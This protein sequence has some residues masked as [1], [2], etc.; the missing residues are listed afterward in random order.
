MP[1]SVIE[2]FEY[3]A[4]QAQLTVTFVTGRVYRYFLV[5]PDCVARFEAAES[6]G[7]FFNRHIRD[8]YP[9]REVTRAA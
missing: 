6:K 4:D 1:S 9:C 5:P 3:D 2:K 7:G 8:K